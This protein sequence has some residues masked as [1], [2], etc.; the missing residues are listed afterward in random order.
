M[1][2]RK[3]LGII[4][5]EQGATTPE[6]VQRALAIQ[7]Q[8]NLKIGRLLVEAR[9]ISEEQLAR[10]L[11]AQSRMPLAKMKADMT[12]ALA[13]VVPA[14]QAEKHHAIAFGARTVDGVETIYVAIGDPYDVAGMEEIRLGV[15][16]PIKFALAPLDEIQ[17]ALSRFALTGRAQPALSAPPSSAH[18]PGSPPAGGPAS[19]ESLDV[20]FF[21][22]V[23]S[24]PNVEL[25]SVPISDARQAPPVTRSRPEAV[26]IVRFPGPS[27]A[28][29]S[30]RLWSSDAQ[31]EPSS[32]RSLPEGDEAAGALFE[33]SVDADVDVDATEAPAAQ[34]ESAEEMD[35]LPGIEL[36]LEEVDREAAPPD[37]AAHGEDLPVEIGAADLEIVSEPLEIQGSSSSASLSQPELAVAPS[38]TFGDVQDLPANLAAEA[39]EESLLLDEAQGEDADGVGVPRDDSQPYPARPAD[40]VLAGD[41]D[42]LSSQVSGVSDEATALQAEGQNLEVPYSRE[43]DAEVSSLPKAE[44]RGTPLE[45]PG[46]PGESG[47]EETSMFP[48][49]RFLY[50]LATSLD[51]SVEDEGHGS[52]TDEASPNPAGTADLGTATL[53]KPS[54]VE[55]STETVAVDLAQVIASEPVSPSWVTPQPGE[56]A[57]A[58]PSR[59]DGR[60][61]PGLSDPPSEEGAPPALGAQAHAVPAMEVED[62]D[63]IDI[64]EQT[65]DAERGADPISSLNAEANS[66]PA[67]APKLEGERSAAARPSVA[68]AA[69]TNGIVD[70]LS[71]I[72]AGQPSDSHMPVFAAEKLGQA[73]VKVLLDRNLVTTQ[74]LLRLV[75]IPADK[76]SAA[77]VGILLEHSV[78][79]AEDVVSM[80]TLSPERVNATILKL[81]L[82]RGAATPEIVAKAFG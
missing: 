39:P 6:V 63:V 62:E 24:P 77:V 45:G 46:A 35:I 36:S 34:A 11:S 21:M 82:E 81:L 29:S 56:E 65:L 9:A 61:N 66:A 5:I 75:A 32:N 79:T 50:E 20:P 7:P 71:R 76:L 31:T 51:V 3:K 68:A 80:L 78:L 49:E 25:P 13:T 23:Q 72:A 10:A 60:E 15:G 17:R 43:A 53:G 16:K 8:K 22:E 59:N 27:P 28:T 48:T 33:V 58:V 19:R 41:W 52:A 26:P 70:A 42:E 64:V 4:L 54:L 67:P 57:L 73:A 12:P 55:P 14:E 1:P 69:T 40:A 30:P 37:D 74:D 2:I 44:A 47:T 18:A 38:E